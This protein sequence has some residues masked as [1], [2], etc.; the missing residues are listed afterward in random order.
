MR[1]RRW[2]GAAC[3]ALCACVHGPPSPR[4][5]QTF[6]VAP[7]NFNQQLPEIL[8]PG[9]PI[10]HDQIRALLEARG[11]RVITPAFAEFHDAWLT[12][13]KEVST[14]YDAKGNLDPARFDSAV[15]A[16][17]R[18]YGAQLE[19][20]DAMLLAY[21]EARAVV[22]RGGYAQWDGVLRRVRVQFQDHKDSHLPLRGI[23]APCTSLR[24]L[25]YTPE[26]ARLF[27]RR[28]GL[29]VVYDFEV[30]P[31]LQV[32]PRG[33]LFRD[34]RTLREGV[35]QALAPLLRD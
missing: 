23:E 8:A 35:Q 19:S 31:G 12:S 3:I 30:S 11:A 10:L 28:A 21:L 20:F 5:A 14:L 17:A 29:E 25:A 34:D 2:I 33:D 24:V 26:G 18:S 32:I 16:L 22:I 7:L 27:D 6:V 4:A 15:A 1:G 9:V 13:A